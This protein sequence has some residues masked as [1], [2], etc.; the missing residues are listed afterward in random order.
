MEPP[1]SGCRHG[2]DKRDTPGSTQLPCR[3]QG[4]LGG[5][6]GVP[7]ARLEGDSCMRR[8]LDRH[9]GRPLATP[10]ALL[11]DR[12]AS[13]PPGLTWCFLPLVAFHTTQPSWQRVPE[14]QDKRQPLGGGACCGPPSSI[15]HL[16]ESE[17]AVRPGTGVS[18]MLCLGL[19]AGRSC[20]IQCGLG[21]GELEGWFC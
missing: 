14:A 20:H 10:S 5:S 1:Q 15:G 18:F 3:W 17:H 9:P 13:V 4:P 11:S 19:G 12:K 6:T 2:G 21:L 7:P 16:A 8:G